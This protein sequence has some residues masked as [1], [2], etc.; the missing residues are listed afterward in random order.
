MIQNYKYIDFISGYAILFVTE[1]ISQM[2]NASFLPRI[3]SCRRHVYYDPVMTKHFRMVM[4]YEIDYNAGVRVMEL[5]GQLYPL[6]P[7]QIVFRKP[8][9]VVDSQGASDIYMLTLDYSH[10]IFP[11]PDVLHATS[12]HSDIRHTRTTLQ[13]P[14]DNELLSLLPPVFEP[15]HAVE[16]LALYQQLALSF[17][18]P[19]QETETQALLS[20][21]LHLLTADALAARRTSRTLSAAGMAVNYLNEHFTRRITLEELAAAVHRDKSYLIRC[22]KKETGL[23]PIAYL[24]RIRLAHARQ[25]LLTSDLSTAEIALQCGFE[26]ASYFT[27]CFRRHYGITPAAFRQST[28]RPQQEKA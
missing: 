25:M 18:R 21:L 6:S 2:S 23:T 13:P 20:E 26:D 22:F 16:L 5:D 17:A 7:G 9:Q 15:R 8:G 10:T 14:S 11:T 19:G 1:V 24:L 3:L 28:L 4:D 27:L 12:H